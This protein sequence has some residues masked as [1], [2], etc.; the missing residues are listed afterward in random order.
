MEG[1]AG[2]GGALDIDDGDTGAG[3]GGGLQV[4]LLAG[5]AGGY[6]ERSA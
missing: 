2:G 6:D 4:E 5:L 1:V 3:Q